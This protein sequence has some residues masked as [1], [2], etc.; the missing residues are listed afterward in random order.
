MTVHGIGSTSQ[1]TAYE[2][3]E[4]L[5]RTPTTTP[6]DDPRAD[7]VTPAQPNPMQSAG[8]SWLAKATDLFDRIAIDGLAADVRAHMASGRYGSAALAAAELVELLEEREGTPPGVLAQARLALASARLAKGDIR[9]AKHALRR[10]DV[11]DLETP[12]ARKHHRA[13]TKAASAAAA[14]KI[15]AARDQAKMH[16]VADALEHGRTAE[17]LRLLKDLASTSEVPATQ[18][19]AKRIIAALEGEVLATVAQKASAE[20]SRLGALKLEKTPQSG[21]ALLNPVTSVKMIAGHYDNLD[22]IHEE[23]LSA[24][25]RI[26]QGARAATSLMQR[27]GLTLADLRR[28][29]VKD[30]SARVGRGNALAIKDVLVNDDVERAAAGRLDGFSWDRN[31]AYVDATYLDTEFDVIGKWVGAQ[32]R[33]ARAT[34]GT[35]SGSESLAYRLVG[36]AS[37]TILDGASA[38]NGELKSATAVAHAYWSDPSRDS[39]LATAAGGAVTAGELLAMPVTAPLTLVDVNATDDERADAARM[40][41]AMLATAGVVKGGAPAFGTLAKGAG[42]VAGSKA[43]QTITAT[44]GGQAVGAVVRRVATSAA[45]LEARFEATAFAKGADRVK[46]FLTRAN[47]TVSVE[48]IT[49]RYGTPTAVVDDMVLDVTGGGATHYELVIAEAKAGGAKTAVSLAGKS[50]DELR[51]LFEARFPKV[52]LEKMRAA[53]PKVAGDSGRTPV[54]YRSLSQEEMEQL[55]STGAVHPIG[56]TG[57]ATDTMAKSQLARA[58]DD[59]VQNLAITEHQARKLLAME[60]GVERSKWLLDNVD[61]HLLVE[62]HQQNAY[63]FS[64]MSPFKSVSLGPHYGPGPGSFALEV[65]DVG[66]RFIKTPSGVYEGEWLMT[67]SLFADEVGAALTDAQFVTRFGKSLDEIEKVRGALYGP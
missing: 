51:A 59:L 54:F 20:R 58:P 34:A 3:E 2:Q 62:A 48:Q 31:A 50:E 66:G 30:L 23:N 65:F 27:E 37:A 24:L 47:P 55:L 17:A 19:V 61:H 53:A 38:V 5:G 9:G 41:A 52:R 6:R 25:S 1:A 57:R 12:A 15:R 35:L 33:G 4:A 22:V 8:G 14:A 67:G 56:M 42:K 39:W 10:I 29:S 45:R 7:T 28:M 49:Q 43:V 60:P 26:E 32:V 16:Q 11:D 36:E 46:A 21:W 44:K 40:T 64:F 63:W 13:L 18:K